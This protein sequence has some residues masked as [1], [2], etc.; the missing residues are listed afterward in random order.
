MKNDERGIENEELHDLSHRPFDFFIPHS[1]FF[2]HHCWNLPI[3]TLVGM[4]RIIEPG[5][6]WCNRRVAKVCP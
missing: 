4:L 2:V 5:V 1:S 6:A 3:L